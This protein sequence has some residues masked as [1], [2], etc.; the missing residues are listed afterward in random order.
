MSRTYKDVPIRL[1]WQD[2]PD[3]VRTREWLTV[4]HLSKAVRVRARRVVD[5]KPRH[6]RMMRSLDGA[7]CR[8]RDC[9]KVDGSGA[10]AKEKRSWTKEVLNG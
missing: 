7:Y 2:M 1:I 3:D 10:R 9:C 5:Y 4:A 8:R 6:P